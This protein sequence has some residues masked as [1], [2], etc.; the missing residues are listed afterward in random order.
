MLKK[1]DLP[2]NCPMVKADY[3][4]YCPSPVIGPETYKKTG[5]CHRQKECSKIVKDFKKMGIEGSSR[6]IKLFSR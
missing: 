6:I 3:E 1:E 4:H 2:S 5:E